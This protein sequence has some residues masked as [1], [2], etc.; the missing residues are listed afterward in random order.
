[1]KVKNIVIGENLEAIL[2]TV[3]IIVL[4]CLFLGGGTRS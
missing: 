3:G 4:F 2:F 1:M